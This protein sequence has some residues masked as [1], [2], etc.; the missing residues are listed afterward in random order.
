MSMISGLSSHVG[1]EGEL[2]HQLNDSVLCVQAAVLGDLELL[3]LSEKALDKASSELVTFLQKLLL[4]LEK[5]SDD[6]T[7]SML[8]ENIRKESDKPIDEW[9]TDIR[10]LIVSL[11]NKKLKEDPNLLQVIEDILSLLS[12]DYSAAVKALYYRYR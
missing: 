9:K 12:A 7:I 4:A 2:L 5:A 11:K 1:Q 8:V 10:T 6:P 3:G